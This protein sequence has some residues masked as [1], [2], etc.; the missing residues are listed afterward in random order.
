MASSLRQQ[1]IRPSSKSKSYNFVQ[2]VGH[3]L[4]FLVLQFLAF[5]EFRYKRSKGSK[6]AM[7]R[8]GML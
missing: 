7:R 6:K 5:L 3:D 2:K 1:K 4:N 8:F